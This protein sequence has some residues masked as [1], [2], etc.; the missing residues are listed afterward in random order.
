MDTLIL[1]A[2]KKAEWAANQYTPPEDPYKRELHWRV[3]SNLAHLETIAIDAAARGDC[4]E[5]QLFDEHFHYETFAACAIKAFGSVNRTDTPTQNLID[6]LKSLSGADSIHVLNIVAE[7]WL[8]VVFGYLAKVPD[9]IPDVF[10]AIEEDE[11]R[12]SHDARKLNV[13]LSDDIETVVRN[14]EKML[15]EIANAPHFM[16][17]LVRVLGRLECSYMGHDLAV[18]HEDA[19]RHL[20]VTPRV[21][22][23]KALARNGRNLLKNEPQEIEHSPWDNIKSR[24]WKTAN[25]AKQVA[26]IDIDIPVHTS[27]STMNVQAR[28]MR[29]L[30]RIYT[31]NEELLRVYRNGQIYRP[32]SV[33]LGVRI[34]HKDR[35]QVGT[36]F[37][38]PT[39]YK[40]NWRLNKMLA[41]RKR[42]MNR[43][44]YEDIPD[45]SDLEK[46]MYPS[47]AVA[48]V[49]SNGAHGGYWGHG[50]L[51]DIEGIGTAFTVGQVRE[52]HFTPSE[53]LSGVRK[54]T[55]F[56]TLAI[57]MDH[58][59]S[60][61]KE[62]GQMA[63]LVKATFEREAFV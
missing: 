41:R 6:Y 39:K 58:R 50:P 38:N 31:I 12:H 10:K 40:D 24:M 4:I 29:A 13:E 9:F 32:Q 16:L 26:Y 43:E 45:M 51:I 22:R 44:Q 36:I 53:M 27:K 57:V 14:V 21:S 1:R 2:K 60:N 54:P 23:I 7:S 47:Y 62:I 19:C 61:G 25:E 28:L 3:L 46:F 56:F 49:S 59:M 63:K 35:E 11:H 52:K 18:S 55:H 20:G 48:T 5:G 34:T 42:R 8:G 15:F 17:P 30:G 33:V 37:F